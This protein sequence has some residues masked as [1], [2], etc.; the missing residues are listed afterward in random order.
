MSLQLELK[1]SPP[2]IIFHSQAEACLQALLGR[3][4]DGRPLVCEYSPVTDFSEARC[5]QYHD[6]GRLNTLQP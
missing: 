4:Y 3:Y 1:S 2:R 6:D 5:R